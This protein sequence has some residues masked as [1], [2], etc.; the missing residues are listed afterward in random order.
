[1]AALNAAGSPCFAGEGTRTL[2][3]QR[4]LTCASCKDLLPHSCS[5]AVD[6]MKA[7]KTGPE[8]GSL[9]GVLAVKRVRAASAALLTACCAHREQMCGM[10]CF[11]SG[12]KAS[13]GHAYGRGQG[14]CAMHC[15]PGVASGLQPLA[16][17]SGFD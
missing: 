5:A 13:A 7:P 15:D 10:E 17:R 6:T 14:G 8:K 11:S 16:T 1:M 2:A 12:V 4:A 9:P 3:Q